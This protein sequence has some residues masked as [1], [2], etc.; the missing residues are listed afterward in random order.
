MPS[1]ADTRPSERYFK[2][3]P[4]EQKIKGRLRGSLNKTHTSV[5]I[6][7]LEAY[8]QLGGVDGLVS[9]GRKSPDLFYPMLKAL[10]PHELAESGAGQQIRV[11]VYGQTP[12]DIKQVIDLPASMQVEQAEAQEAAPSLGKSA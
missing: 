3:L 7:L 2:N 6:A 10:L 11:I 8:R 12:S 9:W 5:R 4:V 1:L